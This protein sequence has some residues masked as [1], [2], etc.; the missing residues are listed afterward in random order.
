MTDG[1]NIE[2]ADAIEAIRL[3]LLDAADRGHGQAIQFEVGPVTLDFTVELTRDARAKGGVKAWVLTTDAE[4]GIKSTRTH[5]VSVTL[6]PK[7]TATGGNVNVS[8]GD[9]GSRDGF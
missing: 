2:L 4:A 5:K 7:N 8:N 9:L 3:G 6:T 1:Q